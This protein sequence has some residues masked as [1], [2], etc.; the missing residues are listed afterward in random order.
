MKG[1]KLRHRLT[2][3]LLAFAMI[4]TAVAVQPNCDAFAATKVKT[5]VATHGRLSVNGGQ[6]WWMPKARNS[7]SRGISTHG[8]NWDV[9]YPYV[10]KAAFKTLRDDWGVNAVR[11][12][13]YTSEYN[14]YCAGGSKAALRNQIYKGVEICDRPRNVCDHRLA[15]TQ[16]RESYDT[17]CRGKKILC[18]YGEEV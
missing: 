6:I 15:H 16:R 17:G 11:L 4:F 2:A 18:N 13:M 9:G 1:R 3:L 8:I 14:G 7:S 5:P 12:A 10:N